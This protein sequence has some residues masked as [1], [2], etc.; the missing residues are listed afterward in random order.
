MSDSKDTASTGLLFFL[1]G[2]AVGA[3]VVALTTPKTGPELRTN[4]KDMGNSLR[5]KVRRATDRVRA[6][7][8]EVTQG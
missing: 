4:L 3:V 7:G 8:E 5:E 6:D 2:A 1:L